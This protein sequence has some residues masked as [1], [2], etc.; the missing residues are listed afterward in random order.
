MRK[1]NAPRNGLFA[2]VSPSH[3]G[4]QFRRARK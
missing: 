3:F 2:V 1:M 4:L